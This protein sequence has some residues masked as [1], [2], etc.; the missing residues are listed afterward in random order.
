MQQTLV[1]LPAFKSALFLIQFVFDGLSVRHP[2]IADRTHASRRDADK[3][4]TA[5]AT[6]TSGANG[7][8]TLAVN[9]ALSRMAYITD[10]AGLLQIEQMPEAAAAAL[11]PL[12]LGEP[13]VAGPVI[14]HLFSAV[15]DGGAVGSMREIA[16]YNAGHG[17]S[18]LVRR[19]GDRARDFFAQSG[20]PGSGSIVKAIELN[21][22]C[23][24]FVPK[25]CSNTSGSPSR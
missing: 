10:A 14:L 24:G 6:E 12:P 9:A 21:A 16:P 3:A 17:S 2:A 20:Q 13:Q 8:T 23:A 15:Q 11:G 7:T 18:S 22:N 4:D 19:F 1:R 25:C 5:L